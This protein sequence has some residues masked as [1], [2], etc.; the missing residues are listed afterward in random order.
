VIDNFGELTKSVLIGSDATPVRERFLQEYASE[1]EDFISN[2]ESAFIHW[3][4]V[5]P[6]FEA[7]MGGAHV[8][9][10]VYGSLATHVTSMKLFLEG[11]MIPAG[12]AQRYVLESIAMALLAANPSLGFRERYARG[13]YSTSKAIR[14]LKRNAKRLG[15]SSGGAQQLDDHSKLYDQ[16]SHP[17]LLTL[18]SLMTLREL[19]S[20]TVFGSVF[21]DGKKAA[22]DRE[23]RSRVS[24]ASVLPN[25]IEGV[26]DNF[27]ST[28]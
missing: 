9:A 24:L 1:V 15:I 13:E 22:Y 11:L 5:A 23:I 18:A 7:D 28:A 17:T 20:K 16:Y 6:D 3:A 25:Y 2:M 21:D 27:R 4:K 12:N 19:E 26:H 10:L 14:D 8:S